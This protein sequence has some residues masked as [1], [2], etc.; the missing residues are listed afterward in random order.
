MWS[1]EM[2]NTVIIETVVSYA[3]THEKQ[4]EKVRETDCYSKSN[5]NRTQT[6]SFYWLSISA[7][8]SFFLHNDMTNNNLPNQIKMS[9]SAIPNIFN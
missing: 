3:M 9:A 6:V 5:R 1:I 4:K 8:V 2:K 7:L